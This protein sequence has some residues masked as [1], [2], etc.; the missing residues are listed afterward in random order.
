MK[1]FDG[2]SLLN[3]VDLP[4]YLKRVDKELDNVLLS[5][6][7]YIREP[8]L[9]LIKAKSKR[10]RPSLLLAVLTSRG[11]TV[12][13]KVIASCVAIELVHIASLV[14]DDIIDNGQT[15][16]MVPTI[17]AKEGVNYAVMIGDY[18]FAKANQQAANV[19]LEVAKIIAKT[20][21]QLCEGEICEMSD[22][23][24]VDRS[25]SSLMGT[26]EGKTAAL[27]S[28]SCR[29]G[30][31]CSGLNNADIEALDKFGRFFG[32]AFQ[33]IDDIL[34]FLSNQQI[35]G[36]AVGNDVRE[37]VYTMPLLLGLAGKNGNRLKNL[38]KN[39]NG[40]DELVNFLL[41]DGS[42]EKSIHLINEYNI[43]A[44]KELKNFNDVKT[45]NSLIKLPESYFKW[46]IENLVD[47]KYQPDI[48]DI[49][50]V[51]IS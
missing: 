41:K 8:I 25:I 34:D 20:I 42:F 19:S 45:K 44:A 9:R 29:I 5:D 21:E 39:K 28:A 49:L 26:I 17:N 43:L 35:L 38:I 13:K 27:I 32:I 23:F 4:A 33:F 50:K 12:D 18:L 16:W 46:S 30:G 22:E 36:K 40:N 6:N 31:L 3:I 14:H 1:S 7:P 15:R 10:I 37:G 2:A 48:N 47:K 51:L 11:Q 24:N